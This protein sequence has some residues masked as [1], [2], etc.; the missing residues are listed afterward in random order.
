M[1][2]E[3]EKCSEP[4][5]PPPPPPHT[6]PPV[7][8]RAH[9]S[10]C[11]VRLWRI[12]FLSRKPEEQSCHLPR[13]PAGPNTKRHT[14]SHGGTGVLALTSSLPPA[15]LGNTQL[16]PGPTTRS[17]EGEDGGL[18]PRTQFHFLVSAPAHSPHPLPTYKVPFSRTNTS[19]A[20]S[21]WPEGGSE[22]SLRERAP[23]GA[24]VALGSQP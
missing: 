15:G 17:P 13:S 21:K 14:L 24:G 4:L 7:W 23:S 3:L 8:L 22:E 19:R 10:V 2:R 9:V 16:E 5:A 18:P 20:G 1:V 12:A 6:H 11:L